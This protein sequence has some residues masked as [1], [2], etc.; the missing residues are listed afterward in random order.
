VLHPRHKLECFKNA[1][2]EDEWVNTA[3]HIIH[4]KY[5]HSYARPTDDDDDDDDDE[6]TGNEDEIN[7]VHDYLIPSNDNANVK[8]VP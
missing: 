4:N 5:E 8:L 2:W 6:G 7:L 1:G 3:E